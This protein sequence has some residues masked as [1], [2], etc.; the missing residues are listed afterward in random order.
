[1]FNARDILNIQP[2]DQHV[3]SILKYSRFRRIAHSGDDIPSFLRE[4]IRTRLANARR[5]PSDQ[6]G[7]AHVFAF[8]RV[9]LDHD[10]QL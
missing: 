10:A 7:L 4:Q 8:C 9:G 6:N 2:A 5:G 3:P 1:M